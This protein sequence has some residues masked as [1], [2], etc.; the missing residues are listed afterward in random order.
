MKTWRYAILYAAT[1][2]A[3]GCRV[4]PNT[5]LLEQEL[6]RQSFEIDRLQAELEDA[7]ADLGACRRDNSALRQGAPTQS[8]RP[9]LPLGLAAPAGSVPRE[10][11]GA[12]APTGESYVDPL[13]IEVPGEAQEAPPK[14]L[15]PRSPARDSGPRDVAPPFV[16]PTRDSSPRAKPP[17]DAAIKTDSSHVHRISLLP[18]ATRGLDLDSRKGD[19]GVSVMIQTWDA[20][21]RLVQA[22]GEVSVVVLDREAEGE[23]AR[24]ARW[25]FSPQQLAEVFQRGSAQDGIYLEMNWPDKPP[26]HDRLQM[27]VRYTTE[28]GRKLEAEMP[29][30]INRRGQVAKQWTPAKPPDPEI[31]PPVLTPPTV[32][33]SQREVRPSSTPVRPAPPKPERHAERPTWSPYR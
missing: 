31:L 16:P 11:G 17:A 14:T 3:S 15:I 21:G 20:K 30:E 13:R 33:P 2:L 22:P 29:L 6:R 5:V 1:L 10:K 18:E 8:K 27:F 25:D 9:S 28:D 32:E 12:P 19:D 24:V 4:D 26:A 7:Q 23:A